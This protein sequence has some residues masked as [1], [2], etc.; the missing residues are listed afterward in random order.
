MFR[1][2]ISASLPYLYIQAN[3]PYIVCPFDNRH[4]E[5][6]TL[7][8]FKSFVPQGFFITAKPGAMPSTSVYAFIQSV[9][10]PD[11]VYEQQ[12]AYD[13]AYRLVVNV[14]HIEYKQ[15]TDSQIYQNHNDSEHHACRFRRRGPV[16][17]RTSHNFVLFDCFYFINN[18]RGIEFIYILC[19]CK[20]NKNLLMVKI[21]TRIQP[22]FPPGFPCRLP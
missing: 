13:D 5:R 20:I 17:F 1:I 4:M 11:A 14:E 19:A 10:A 9:S 6:F 2:F 21:H 22:R 3:R 12:C 8:P 16:I 15:Q 7:L 18:W